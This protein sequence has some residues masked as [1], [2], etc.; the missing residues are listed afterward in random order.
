MTYQLLTA[1][2]FALTTQLALANE[3]W[4]LTDLKGQIAVSPD[5][6][7]FQADEF[8]N[9]MVLCF[10]EDGTGTVT[11]DDTKFVMFGKSTLMG[12]AAN[13]EIELAET[14][15]IDRV[16]GKVLFIKS[17]IGTASVVPGGPDVAGAY[18]GNASRLPNEP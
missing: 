15:Q 18:I 3:C 14:Y 11:G 5:S 1:V 2:V 13:R 4:T 7:E 17:R 16:N 10:N 9:P 8:S 12:W 6:Y